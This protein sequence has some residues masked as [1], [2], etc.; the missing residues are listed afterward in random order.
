MSNAYPPPGQ[1]PQW[2]QQPP[3]PQWQQPPGP[4]WGGP[5]SAPKK[6]KAGLFVGL[7]CGGALL[8]LLVFIVIGFAVG[9]GDSTAKGK[10]KGASGTA[11]SAPAGDAPAKGE[12]APTKRKDAAPAADDPKGDAKVTGCV[13]EPVTTWPSADVTI[14]N[15][16][17]RSSNYIVAVEFVDGSGARVG[18]GMAAANSVAPGQKVKAKA[19]ALSDTTGKITCKVLKVTRYASG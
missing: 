16:S 15:R 11:S 14:T 1:Q 7:G 5:P 3:S 19:Q 6:S 2:G 13:V 18:E 4:G 17:A 8:L 10:R 12:E 9:D